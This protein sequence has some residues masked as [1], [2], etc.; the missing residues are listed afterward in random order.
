MVFL[1]FTDNTK[2]MDPKV[3]LD[4]H[5][6]GQCGSTVEVASPI[7]HRHGARR[8]WKEILYTVHMCP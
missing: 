4:Y 7:S 1:W 8:V 2:A 5:Q 6:P 3:N